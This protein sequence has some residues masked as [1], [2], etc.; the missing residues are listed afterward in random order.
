MQLLL[1]FLLPIALCHSM[2][3][4]DT[5]VLK[6]HKK[7]LGIIRKT[8]EQTKMCLSTEVLKLQWAHIFG[9]LNISTWKDS[10]MPEEGGH[11]VTS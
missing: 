5:Y 4:S 3:V 10:G 1:S 8:N 2:N 6:Q 7:L 9:S 11:D